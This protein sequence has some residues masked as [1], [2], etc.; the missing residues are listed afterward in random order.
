[1]ACFTPAGDD[2]EY[3][4]AL[5]DCIVT[6]PQASLAPDLEAGDIALYQPFLGE[7]ASVTVAAVD[8]SVW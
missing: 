3:M 2:A 1:M 8:A 7:Q 6:A 5:S 4:V